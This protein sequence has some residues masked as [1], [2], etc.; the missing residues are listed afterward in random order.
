MTNN[1]ELKKSKISLI[2]GELDYLWDDH[3]EIG[4][5]RTLA[6]MGMGPF[7]FL[8]KEK[9]EEIFDFIMTAL[10]EQYKKE[11]K[12]FDKMRNA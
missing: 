10:K 4:V 1:L 12:E 9:N 8:T 11:Q 2:E 7:R 6:K 3:E 5:E